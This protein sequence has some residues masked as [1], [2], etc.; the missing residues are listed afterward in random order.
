[1]MNT[2]SDSSEL[3][4]TSE[5]G[6]PHR[7]SLTPRTSDDVAEPVFSSET[8][9]LT[10]AAPL[11]P[12]LW[13]ALLWIAGFY[14]IEL[15]GGLVW[16][17]I[18]VAIFTLQ[19]GSPPAAGNFSSLLEPYMPWMIGSIK[20]VEVGVILLA[21][22]L[23]FGPRAFEVTG[24]R[25]VPALHAMILVL[26]VVPTAFLSGQCYAL[27]RGFW[28]RL[29]EN[30]PFLESIDQMSSIE[31]VQEMARTT[32]LAALIFIIGVLPALN[33]EFMFRAA[34]GRGLLGR[35]GLIAGIALTSMLFAAMHLSPVH[36]AA[37]LPL[38]VL[39]HVA[40][41]STGSIWSSVGVHFLNNSMSVVLMK[42][43]TVAPEVGGVATDVT[44]A[45]FSPILFTAAAACVVATIWLL[46]KIRVQW[47]LPD[48]AVWQSS[49]VGVEAPP[50]H[51]DATPVTP[52]PPKSIALVA[53]ACYVFFPIAFMFSVWLQQI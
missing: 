24:F 26:A 36:A 1:M 43:A 19:T 42:W 31:T 35:Y 18:A 20:L 6:A 33:E 30:S 12:G 52:M 15:V 28:D 10:R 17:V 11:G 44:E 40:Y 23:R 46:F 8:P 53:M 48:S 13:E 7:D 41:L 14:L 51:V 29:A 2:P 5:V 50:R 27:L 37:L 32:P 21:I 4:A 45:P 49:Q 22:R 34:I 47:T 25:P 16:G 39:M 9:S 38:A 3:E